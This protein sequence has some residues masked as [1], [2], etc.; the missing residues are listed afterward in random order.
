MKLRT[1]GAELM[2]IASY[3]IQ[4]NETIVSIERRVF[5]SLSHYRTGELLKF[6]GELHHGVPVRQILSLRDASQQHVAEKIED[7]DVSRR[8]PVFGCCNSAANVGYIA[9][10]NGAAVYVRPV[11]REACDHFGKRITK[12]VESEVAGVAL[13]QGDSGD[14][15]GQHG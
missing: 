14:L 4:R 2:E 1:R 12:A 8:A 5:Q 9:L 11:Y 10:R 15:I 6:H 3:L 7:T 13:G